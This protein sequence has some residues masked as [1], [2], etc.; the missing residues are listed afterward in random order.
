[1]KRCKTNYRVNAILILCFIIHTANAMNKSD[2]LQYVLSVYNTSDDNFKSYFSSL[3]DSTNLSLKSFEKYFKNPY[4]VVII[5]NIRNSGDYFKIENYYSI[6]KK[7]GYSNVVKP[8]KTRFLL[9]DNFKNFNVAKYYIEYSKKGVIIDT[10]IMIFNINNAI[11]TCNSPIVIEP[12]YN[13]NIIGI[14]SIKDFKENK[15]KDGIIDIYTD[16]TEII[17]NQKKNINCY[18][19]RQLRN[20]AE[21]IRVISTSNKIDLKST[22]QNLDPA[23]KDIDIAFV[24]FVN[25][26]KLIEFDV[27]KVDFI[28]L[29]SF[30]KKEIRNYQIFINTI[31]FKDILKQI[32]SNKTKC[33]DL[34]CFLKD[35]DQ[36]VTN[37]AQ[38]PIKN[39]IES[40]ILCKN[41]NIHNTIN[42]NTLF[43][44]ANTE[45]FKKIIP[46]I[47]NNVLLFTDSILNKYSIRTFSEAYSNFG[48]LLV[49]LS[50][51]KVDQDLV[52][53]SYVNSCLNT[54]SN[55][56]YIRNY[57]Y[58]YLSLFTDN[59][60]QSESLIK[61]EQKRVELLNIDN[62]YE[63]FENAEYMNFDI[64]RYVIST[65]LTNHIS[66]EM[67][68]NWMQNPITL[69]KAVT[70]YKVP[71]ALLDDAIVIAYS[72]EAEIG[73]MK[74]Y[75]PTIVD[76]TKK[77][78]EAISRIDLKKHS[79][80]KGE[81]ALYNVVFQI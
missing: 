5:D 68:N 69:R 65:L 42:Y 25:D 7:Y 74:I 27:D 32:N 62:Y 13:C 12:K 78:E 6:I 70:P 21:Q 48:N 16:E 8:I 81:I 10:F 40:I 50:I 29:H 9:N 24:M 1:M 20:K 22:I 39:L 75:F 14:K 71:L 15:L 2:S 61:L 64:K 58:T 18:T 38:C 55:E 67:I 19:L 80:R 37:I 34:I 26:E 30:Y 45:H 54:S 43:S 66:E 72:V 79:N 76:D 57:V 73:L 33:Y 41:H 47:Y 46:I 31:I 44:E 4:S 53:Y 77:V 63:L 60:N 56:V 36:S 59:K 52:L 11:S 3:K 23:N 51:S 28:I 49:D 17:S 35:I